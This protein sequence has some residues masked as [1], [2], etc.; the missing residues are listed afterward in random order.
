MLLHFL[1][2][3]L[4]FYVKTKKRESSSTGQGGRCL[5]PGIRNVKE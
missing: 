3:L 2:R 5:T 1:S 4:H